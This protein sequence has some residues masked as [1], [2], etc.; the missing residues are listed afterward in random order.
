MS[1]ESYTDPRLAA[2]YDPLNPSF[3]DTVFYCDLAGISPL[4]ILDVGCGTGRLATAMAKL[5][6]TVTGTD[7]ADAMLKLGQTREHGEKVSWHKATALQFSSPEKFD[8]IT[9]NGHVFQVFLDDEEILGVLKNLRNHLSSTGRLAFETRNPP[10]QDW[11]SWKPD[12][13]RK[14]IYV[15]GVGRVTVHYDITLVE[16]EQVTFDTHFEFSDDDVVVSANTLRFI[17]YERL[18]QLINKAGFLDVTVYGD[19]DKSGYHAKKPEIIVVA[20]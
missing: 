16:G 17:P 10:V 8:L 18:M 1:G 6:H 19:W 4:K 13:T 2:V 15:P 11:A 20:G 9:M 7:P 3:D 14:E 12:A 5:G